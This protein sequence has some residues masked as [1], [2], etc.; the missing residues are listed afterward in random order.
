MTGGLGVDTRG[1]SKKLDGL[2]RKLE[3]SDPPRAP[4]ARVNDGRDRQ[5]RKWAAL[6]ATENRATQIFGLPQS[7]QCVVKPG[8]YGE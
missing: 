3:H 7:S 5:A 4:L 8:S 1:W 6:G 2:S